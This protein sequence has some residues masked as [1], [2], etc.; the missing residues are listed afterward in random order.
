MTKLEDLTVLNAFLL[1]LPLSGR[2]LNITEERIV[3][4]EQG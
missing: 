2:F 1:Y 4:G 3:K